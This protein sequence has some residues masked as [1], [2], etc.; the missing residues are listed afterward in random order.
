MP[1]PVSCPHCHEQLDIPA[2]YHGRPVRCANCQN[3]FSAGGGVPVVHRRPDPPSRPRPAFDDARP[4]R[5]SNAGVWLLLVA[6]LFTVGGCCGGFTLFTLV[7]F[8]PTLTPYTSPE[9]KFKVDLPAGQT[10]TAATLAQPAGERVEGEPGWV[11][12]TDRPM[13]KE[14]YVVKRYPLKAEWRKLP[15]DDALA[16]V[17]EVESKALDAGPAS[18]P[19]YRHAIVKHADFPARDVTAAK[20]GF[21]GQKTI[22]RCVLVPDGRVYVLAVQGPSVEPELWWVRKFFLSFDVTD[23]PRPEK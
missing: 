18:G 6:T 23:P 17:A 21:Q 7:Q 11:V 2:E 10:P 9:G 22:L 12:M 15:A 13:V 8:N 14:H 16:K 5:Q 1:D 20:E 19:D 4:P 3:V